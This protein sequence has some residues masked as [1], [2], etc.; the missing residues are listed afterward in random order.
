MG[1]LTVTRKKSFRSFAVP[2]WIVPS[3]VSKEQFMK[4]HELAGDLCTH[5]SMGQPINRMEIDVLNRVGISISNGETIELNVTDNV[6]SIFV[7][8][9]NGSLSNEIKMKEI[10]MNRLFITTKGGLRTVCYPFIE[11]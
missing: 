10:K 9:I 1:V 4:E 6:V 7:I 8:T 5:T 11:E 2:Y 3:V